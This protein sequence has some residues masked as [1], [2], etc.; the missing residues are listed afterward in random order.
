MR[1]CDHILNAKL[2]SFS[3]LKVQICN[4]LRQYN[5]YTKILY[6]NLPSVCDEE[7]I[8]FLENRKENPALRSH[9]SPYRMLTQIRSLTLIVVK[10]RQ[11][12]RINFDHPV[13][14]NDAQIFHIISSFGIFFIVNKVHL[15]VGVEYITVYGII[16]L[17]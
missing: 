7:C 17:K 2:E 15:Q 16:C 1:S 11:C 3:F 6:N 5:M 12:T 13:Q 14:I 9:R 10:I 4:V 8:S